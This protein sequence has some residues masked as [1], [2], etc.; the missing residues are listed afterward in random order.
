VGK[1][2]SGAVGNFLKRHDHSAGSSKCLSGVAM[3]V[4]LF[5]KMNEF[6]NCS[7]GFAGAVVEFIHFADG[8][9]R[10]RQRSA[11]AS[12]KEQAEQ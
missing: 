8:R 11:T 1:Y 6:S 9:T 5:C 3:L 12:S 7:A 2:K 10:K 4:L